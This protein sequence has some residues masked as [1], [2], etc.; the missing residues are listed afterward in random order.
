MI[1][2]EKNELVVLEAMMAEE[3][4]VKNQRLEEEQMRQK[5][6]AERDKQRRTLDEA[7][8]K[9]PNFCPSKTEVTE[10][11]VQRKRDGI[12]NSEME[13]KNYK[14]RIEHLEVSESQPPPSSSPVPCKRRK[15]SSNL[16]IQMSDTV[17]E[18]L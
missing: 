3:D 16:E 11:Q 10:E 13:M 17:P 14:R 6:K 4:L 1:Q 18:D 9:V 8:K 15:D 7:W 12:R 5:H 2:K